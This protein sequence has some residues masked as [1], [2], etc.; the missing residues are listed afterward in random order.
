[1]TGFGWS[2]FLCR[3]LALQENWQYGLRY[4]AT[5][6][7]NILGGKLSFPYFRQKWGIGPK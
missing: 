3:N 5:I 6:V 1:M 7:S 2:V 4:D